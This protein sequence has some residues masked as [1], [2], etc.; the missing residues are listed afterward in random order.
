MLKAKA[1]STVRPL[2]RDPGSPTMRYRLILVLLIAPTLAA[3]AWA[4]IIF[5]RKAKKPDPQTRVPELIAILK[6]DN[7]EGKRAKAAEE[8]AG[9]DATQFPDVVPALTGAL[10]SDPKTGVRLEAAHA[11]AK[12]RPVSQQAGQALEQALS[13]DSSMRVRLKC[14]SMLLQYHWAGY[15]SLKKNDAPPPL[16]TKEPPPA[17]GKV[18]PII[19]TT[20]GPAPSTY[21]VLPSAKPAPPST[22]EPPL[23]P[24][25][26]APTP[27][28]P[29]PTPAP[30]PA[31]P[32]PPAATPPTQGP[33]L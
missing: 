17:D 27:A 2:Q 4:G 5:G 31:A 15:R 13:N 29:A 26:P 30:P 11:L 8:L 19:R 14:R 28:P 24:P 3:P 32:P 18:P 23:A 21:R 25:L 22:A 16:N 20:P 9:Y 7:D 33:A 6:S 10:L 12:V 1:A